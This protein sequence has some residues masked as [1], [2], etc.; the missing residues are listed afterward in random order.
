MADWYT[1]NSA[2]S[3]DKNLS[4]IDAT[5]LGQIVAAARNQVVSLPPLPVK[6]APGEEPVELPAG[7]IP[8]H[9]ALG[10][11]MQIQALVKSNKVGPGDVSGP[12]GFTVRV[13]PMDWNIKAVLRP[14]TTDP[15]TLI[16]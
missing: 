2:K 15:A 1:A 9:W 8:D 5:V 14:P 3:A 6:L 11:L 12:E 13:Y 10:H 4:Q 16:G 7:Q